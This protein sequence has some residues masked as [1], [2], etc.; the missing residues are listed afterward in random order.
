LFYRRL[1]AVVNCRWNG[2]EYPSYSQ[3]RLM[4]SSF[5]IC[6]VEIA[7]KDLNKW[8]C[9]WELDNGKQNCTGTISFTGG[10]TL[11]SLVG[12]GALLLYWQQDRYFF[13]FCFRYGEHVI[14]VSNKIPLF[15]NYKYYWVQL[16]R[17]RLWFSTKTC[18]LKPLFTQLC[19]NMC[20]E[21]VRTHTLLNRV[22]SHWITVLS[23]KQHVFVK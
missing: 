1:L 9:H 23:C 21:K 19:F 7:S 2:P 14:S 12:G 20:N 22:L 16:K 15:S 4:L 17:H 8:I 10:C 18:I 6:N 13:V 11:L 3:T 5:G